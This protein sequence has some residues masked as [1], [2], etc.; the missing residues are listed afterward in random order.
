MRPVELLIVGIAAGVAAFLITRQQDVAASGFERIDFAQRA[1][2]SAAALGN[3]FLEVIGMR[4][5]RNNNPGNIRHSGTRWQG[6]SA[7]QTDPAFVQFIAPE[8]G[9]RAL[10]KLLDTYS[11]QYGLRTVSGIIGRYAPGHENDTASYISAVSS[12]LGVTPAQEFDVQARKADLV[13]A[14]IKHENGLMPYSVAQISGG[15][16]MA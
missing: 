1:A 15:L 10:S 13:R 3:L 14:I 4:G 11:N 8:Y 2:D 5:I 12:A 7:E 16:S 6:M 9:I